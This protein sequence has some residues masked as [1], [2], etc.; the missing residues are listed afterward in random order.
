MSEKQVVEADVV[1][2][3]FG[4]AALSA[5]YSALQDG[6]RVAVLERAPREDRGGN[7]R[8]TEAY[9][10][11]KTDDEVSDDFE[12]RLASNAGFYLDP[13]LVRETGQPR[14]QWSSIV[15][16]HGFTDPEVISAFAD[17]AGPTLAWMKSA[18]VRFDFLP[19]YFLTAAVPRMMPV[20]GGLAIVETLGER[21]ESEGADI[22]FET[23]ARQLIHDEA[24]AVVGVEAVT[25]G[26][27]PVEFRAPSVVLACG[28]FEG[29]PEMMAQYLGP[30]AR[31]LRPIARGGYF[32]RG[33]GIRMGLEAGAA[34]A[35]DFGSYHAEPIDPRSGAAE[36]NVMVF[37]YGILVNR[38][39]RRF[40]DEAVDTV[41]SVY[42]PVTRHVFE[43]T[44]GIAWVVLDGKI[45]DVANWKRAVRSDQ[46]PVT[47]DSLRTLAG[48]LGVDADQLEET[49]AAYNGACPAPEGFK[50]FELD[51]LATT[52]VRP[53]KSNWAR[54]IDSPP[55]RAWPLTSANVFTFGGLKVD[56]SARVVNSDGEVIPGL[57]AA[58]ETMGIFFGH[59][60]G[61]TSVLRGAVFGRIAGRDAAARARGG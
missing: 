48:E 19:T 17:N 41:D 3:G 5:A 42:E 28:G 9:L 39:G 30:R 36:P 35:G 59:Y 11:M 56:T 12:E 26:N 51:G 45:D 27:R 24:G 38:E 18:G 31:Y 40:C 43:Q 14:E 1:V 53:A 60:T 33:E 55:F 23:T 7:T 37:S 54:T 34:P 4:V 8:Y 57:Y 50:P 61:S 44:G 13:E 47:A 46:P 20:G 25:R 16:A 32:N 29:N 58:G 6:A 15:K 22:H 10:R 2:V 52:G 21:L 49:V